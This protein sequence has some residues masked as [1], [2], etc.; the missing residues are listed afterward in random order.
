MY[1]SANCPDEEELQALNAALL[2]ELDRR[3]G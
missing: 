1:D 2:R 3:L